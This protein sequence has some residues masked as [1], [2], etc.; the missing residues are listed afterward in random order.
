MVLRLGGTAVTLWL[1]LAA[2]GVSPGNYDAKFAKSLCRFYEECAAAS[3]NEYY[4]S[5]RDC[6]SE[7]EEQ[8]SSD[9]YEDCTFDGRAA[10]DCLRAVD[11]AT[12]NCDY[13]DFDEEA[14][15]QDVWTCS[16]TASD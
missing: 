5:S 2:C 7:L 4:S 11:E 12:R 10:R 16:G 14:A 1:G 8:L 13:A 6:R 15:C 3:F 9:Y